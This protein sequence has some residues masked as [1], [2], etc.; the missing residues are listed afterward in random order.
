M[1][2]PRTATARVPLDQLARRLMDEG[3]RLC[4]RDDE[5]HEY[6]RLGKPTRDDPTQ[7]LIIFRCGH[8]FADGPAWQRAAATL[9]RLSEGARE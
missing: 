3:F 5:R 1:S 8:I 6:A 4:P 9:V 2:T 7:V